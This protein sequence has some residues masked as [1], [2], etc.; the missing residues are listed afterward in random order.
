MAVRGD[1]VQCAC[2]GLVHMKSTISP[3]KKQLI[4]KLEAAVME[5]N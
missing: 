1:A 5:H 2:I 3:T 4:S